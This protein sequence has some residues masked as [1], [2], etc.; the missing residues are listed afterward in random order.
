MLSK[1]EAPSLLLA[2]SHPP[3]YSSMKLSHLRCG[4]QALSAT[5]RSAA[6]PILQLSPR[7]VM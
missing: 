5:M 1:A 4:P 6:V 3:P 2:L 7:Q